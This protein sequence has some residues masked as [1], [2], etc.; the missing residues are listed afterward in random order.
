MNTTTL[1]YLCIGLMVVNMAGTVFIIVKHVQ[2]GAVTTT[3]VPSI[4]VQDM[5]NVI[6]M[7]VVTDIERQWRAAMAEH[8]EGSPKHTAYANR[9]KSMEAQRGHKHGD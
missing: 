2:A 1:L 6:P 3:V 9:L 4:P 7:A 5:A 8:P